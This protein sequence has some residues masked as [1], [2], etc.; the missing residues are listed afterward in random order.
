[1]ERM[2]RMDWGRPYDIDPN[3]PAALVK[4]TANSPDEIVVWA[5]LKS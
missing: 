4:K 1:M 5:A 3:N 2:E